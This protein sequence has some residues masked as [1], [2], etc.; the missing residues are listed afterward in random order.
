MTGSAG[1]RRLIA[2]GASNL[3]RV[4]LPLLAAARAAGDGP[5]EAHMALGR[6]RSYGVRSRLLGR[7]LSGIDACGLWPALA[8]APAAPGTAV[9]TDVGNDLL[10]H[11]EVPR[12]LDWVDHALQR[13]ADVAGHRIVTGLP[14]AGL[15]RLPA[16]RFALV[17]TVLVPGCRLTLVQALDGA[18]RLHEGLAALAARHRARFVTPEERWFGFDP[19][20]VR[21]PCWHDAVHAWLGTPRGTTATPAIDG[22]L[23]RLR[24]LFAAPAER[25]FLGHGRMHAQPA[26]S[27]ADGSTLSLW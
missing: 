7:G 14:M 19:I 13:L 1:P 4:A 15:R 12:I 8:A 25:T 23:A 16:W 24:F 21:R 2:L 10:Y 18:E 3:A 20:H 11:V 5:V 9:V 22:R 27:W 26:R 6:G 17:K